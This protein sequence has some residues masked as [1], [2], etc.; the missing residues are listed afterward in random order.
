MEVSEGADS[1]YLRMVVYFKCTLGAEVA[2]TVHRIWMYVCTYCYIP[3]CSG[4]LPTLGRQQEG[5]EDSLVS[6]N[7]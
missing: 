2:K 7:I 1:T 6:A 3:T 4:Y 5:K